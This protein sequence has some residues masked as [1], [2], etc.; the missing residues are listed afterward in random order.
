MHF[1]PSG[2]RPSSE[3]SLKHSCPRPSGTPVND[4]PHCN[5]TCHHG[6][7]SC[8]S[9]QNR[10]EQTLHILSHATSWSGCLKKRGQQ[11][12]FDHFLRFRE[13]FGHFLVTFSD[14][15]A[16]FFAIFFAK[17][18]LPDS[19]CGRVTWPAFNLGIV[20]ICV[21]CMCWLPI[22]CSPA[23]QIFLGPA[24]FLLFLLRPL[25]PLPFLSLFLLCLDGTTAGFKT[26]LP[27]EDVHDPLPF[28]LCLAVL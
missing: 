18:L 22:E 9:K 20:H 4:R 17:L 28:P 13:S 2:P 15:S 24:V 7:M 21:Q 19:F 6:P 3:R 8:E 25:F 26:L 11:K 14:V 16:T 1:E 5:S 23:I 12:E 10:C 27:C